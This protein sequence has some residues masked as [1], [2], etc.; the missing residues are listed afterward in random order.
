VLPPAQVRYQARARPA[1]QARSFSPTGFGIAPLAPRAA[2]REDAPLLRRGNPMLPI[3]EALA[4]ILQACEPL[5]AERVMLT[6]ALG[7]VLASDVIGS[8]LLPPHDGSMRDG[9]AVRSQNLAA[10]SP[11][12]PV[13]LRVV[14]HVAAG[15]AAQGTI[16]V[17][18]AARIFTGAPIPSGADTVV[19]QE[20]VRREGDEAVFDAPAEPGDFV[21]PAGSE[22][23]PGERVLPR[24]TVLGP[25]CLG[26]LAELGRS[27]I[28]VHRRPRVALL[29][30]GDELR[31]L[32]EPPGDAIVDSSSWSIAAQI[33]LA[34]GEPVRLPVARDDRNAIARALESGLSCDVIVTNAGASVGEHDFS[35]EALADVGATLAFWKIAI[36]PGKPFAFGTRGR[37]LFFALPG[38]PVSGMVCFEELVRPALLRLQGHAA[39]E[40][41]RLLAR[42]ERPI[43]KE[44][45]LTYFIRARTR[46]EQGRLVT[47]PVTRQD[48]GLVSAMVEA[49]SLIVLDEGLEGAEAGA[50]VPVELLDRLLA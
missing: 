31:E 2:L 12:R 49:N 5:S 45:T 19:M 43:R 3:H 46:V 22:S 13:R 44:K 40:R 36:R 10:A 24:G 47:E 4:R 20:R 35:K 38:N 39:V 15:H 6:E 42:L 23:K 30:T 26:V 11:E 1:V 9:Y 25:A 48:S 32:D 41:P 33:A 16:G 50:E 28:P 14:A 29:A 8:S 18:E 34:G 37:Q 21:R 7:R 17:G 27:V